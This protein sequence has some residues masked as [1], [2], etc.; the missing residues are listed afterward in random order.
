M[1]SIAEGVPV[2]AYSV[3]IPMSGQVFY[4]LTDFTMS[5]RTFRNLIYTREIKFDLDYLHFFDNLD[6]LST[7]PEEQMPKAIL[8]TIQVPQYMSPQ[9]LVDRLIAGAYKAGLSLNDCNELVTCPENGKK[10]PRYMLPKY[11]KY[12]INHTIDGQDELDRFYYNSHR[13]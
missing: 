8:R 7:I 3:E 11:Q 1:M 2:T 6:E 9:Y 10:V 4:G 13:C 12:I 5:M